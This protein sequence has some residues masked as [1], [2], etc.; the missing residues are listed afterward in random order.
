MRMRVLQVSTRWTIH[1]VDDGGNDDGE[2]DYD[3][4]EDDYDDDERCWWWTAMRVL[5][6]STRLCDSPDGQLTS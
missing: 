4:G 1:I 5:Q 2:D 6:V 3:D